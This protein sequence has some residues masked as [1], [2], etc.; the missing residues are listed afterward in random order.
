MTPGFELQI[1]LFSGEKSCI[2]Q[3]FH[4][5]SVLF[6]IARYGLQIFGVG[7]KVGG[8]F[9]PLGGP[10]LFF[11]R[12]GFFSH[13]PPPAVCAAAFETFSRWGAPCKEPRAHMRIHP[14]AQSWAISRALVPCFCGRFF[15]LF[16][17]PCARGLRARP[18]A[19]PLC[20]RYPAAS[21]CASVFRKFLRRLF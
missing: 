21:C 12:D 1:S 10:F 14:R 8:N 2:F 3:L 13:V 15:G 16:T 7:E 17:I 20:I 4:G 9:S 5:L 11:R 6:H 18:R 19:A